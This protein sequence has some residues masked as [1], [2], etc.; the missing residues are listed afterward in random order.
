MAGTPCPASAR[1][2]ARSAGRP[3]ATPTWSTI[4]GTNWIALAPVPTTATRVPVERR[5]RGATGPSGTPARRRTPAGSSGTTGSESWPTAE[6]T[7][8][9][10]YVVPSVVL[11]RQVAVGVVVRRLGDLL[12]GAHQVEQ[13]GVA[14]GPLE[15]GE[16]LGLAGVA[17]APVR[18]ERPRPRVERRRHVAGRARVG[19][20]APDAADRVGALEDRD[21]LD[22][23]LPQRA[24]RPQPAEAGADDQTAWAATPTNLGRSRHEQA[25]AQ[26]MVMP[27][28]TARVWPVM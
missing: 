10:S 5:R 4:A 2:T 7:T 23:L 12:A 25:L 13:P 14:R 19:V 24:G 11:T 20:V 21:V 1:R 18:V 16:D 8:S 6:I 28:S 26:V 22:A 9:A 15:V 17:V 27:P 3:S